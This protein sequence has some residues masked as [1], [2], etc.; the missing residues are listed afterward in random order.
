MKISKFAGILYRIR[1]L[2][3]PDARLQFYYS[4]IFPH[5]TYNIIVWENTYAYLLQNLFLVQKRVVRNVVGASYLAH[6]SPIFKEF[7]ILKLGDL[8]KFNI[9]I[10]MHKQMNSSS[11]QVLHD[12]N[13]RNRDLARPVR[14]RLAT[15]Q[16]LAVSHNGPLEWNSLPPNLR[17]IESIG[18][19]KRELKQHI[20]G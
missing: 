8:Y 10:Y 19:F 4:F 11:Y 14:H 3:T 15:C 12:L 13:T 5:L 16:K 18:R 9:C 1:D 6:T 17:T 2:L 20:L 7:S